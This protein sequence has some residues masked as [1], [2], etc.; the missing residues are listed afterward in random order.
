MILNLKR[1][2]RRLKMGLVSPLILLGCIMVFKALAADG[3]INSALARG[4]LRA[5]EHQ[6]LA[7]DRQSPGLRGHLCWNLAY[8]CQGRLHERKMHSR[9]P[10]REAR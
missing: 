5:I 4:R 9:S 10:P 7:P 6:D 2:S 1:Y 8:D 3:G